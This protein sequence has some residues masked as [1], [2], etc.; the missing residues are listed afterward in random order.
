MCGGQ[1]D[2]LSFL[3]ESFGNE[4][5]RERERKGLLYLVLLG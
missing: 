4:L 1:D 2:S 3:C 5:E